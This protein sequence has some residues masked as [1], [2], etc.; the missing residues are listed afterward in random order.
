MVSHVET[1]MFQMPSCVPGLQKHSCEPLDH[2]A[3]DMLYG[4]LSS[5]TRKPLQACSRLCAPKVLGSAAK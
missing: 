3:Q 5:L 1:G 2:S 4:L